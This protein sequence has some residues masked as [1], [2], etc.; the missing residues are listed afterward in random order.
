VLGAQRAW[1]LYRDSY[2]GPSHTLL[3]VVLP[4]A[5]AITP[6]LSC[7]VVAHCVDQG[8]TTTALLLHYYCTLLLHTTAHNYCATAAHY[9]T[10]LLHTTTAL[11]LRYYCTLL[12]RYYY[13]TLILHYYCTTTVLL[14]HY[15]CT[16]TAL[17]LHTTT[18][19]LLQHTTTALLLLHYCCTLLLHR[20]EAITMFREAAMQVNRGQE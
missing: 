14:L 12:L 10:Q 15:Y 1:H 17:L 11:L 19:L 20:P 4:T 16:T 13:C 8:L 7:A 5:T 2:E 9:C 6:M 18:A 3:C